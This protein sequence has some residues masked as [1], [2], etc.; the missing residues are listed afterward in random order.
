M[1]G[2]ES[3]S[4]ESTTSTMVDGVATE[5][6]FHTLSNQRRRFV[7]HALEQERDTLELR[8]LSTQIAAWENRKDV[9]TVTSQERRR[10]YNSLQQVHLPQMDDSGLVMYDKRS[11]TIEATSDIADLQLYLEVIRGN[12]I[13]WSTYYLL[14]GVF[15]TLFAGAAVAGVPLLASI[16]PLLAALVPGL[17]LTASAG[18]H[19]YVS[20]QRRL[21]SEGR[22]PELDR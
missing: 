5:D 10:V 19:T 6:A 11:G 21:G 7:V 4:C 16:P 1:A 8:T 22:P 20:R 13:P 15:A 14:L 3:L 17:L 9:Q 2:G 18:V 12:D